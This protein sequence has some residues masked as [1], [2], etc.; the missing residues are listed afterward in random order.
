MGNENE[1]S[2]GLVLRA[3]LNTVGCGE[4]RLRGVRVRGGGAQAVGAQRI[5][6]TIIAAS[7]L[8]LLPFHSRYC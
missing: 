8:L 6:P 3:S 5:L 1:I 2:G 7:L 4:R